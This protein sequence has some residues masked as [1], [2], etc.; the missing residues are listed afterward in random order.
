[1]TT[2]LPV[3][4]R[5]HQYTEHSRRHTN[6]YVRAHTHTHTHAHTHTHSRIHAHTHTHAYTHT[7]THAHTHTHTHTHKDRERRRRER[8]GDRQRQTDRR[9]ET[10]REVEHMQIR[11]NR[12]ADANLRHEAMLLTHCRDKRQT[13]GI[14]RSG[15]ECLPRLC[16]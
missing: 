13:D 8:G 15:V 9:T 2:E 16:H 4:V 5:S 3:H 7:R 1:M 10:E 6:A 11:D 12:A 14:P